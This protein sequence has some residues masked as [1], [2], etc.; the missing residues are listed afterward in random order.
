MVTTHATSDRGRPLCE[1]TTPDSSGLVVST[2]REDHVD[3]TDCL[4]A[5]GVPL[6]LLPW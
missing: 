4:A 1:T 3:C 6:C 2:P 5:L